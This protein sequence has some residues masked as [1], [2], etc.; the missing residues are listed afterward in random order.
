MH[1]VITKSCWKRWSAS[2]DKVVTVR[3]LRCAVAVTKYDK[4][5][6]HASTPSMLKISKC[7]SAGS[8]TSWGWS[9]FLSS[10]VTGFENTTIFLRLL[11]FQCMGFFIQG[12]PSH[13]QL[14]FLWPNQSETCQ[15]R[16]TQFS[17]SKRNCIPKTAATHK[18]LGE[19]EQRTSDC[20]HCLHLDEE[21]NT[22]KC[23]KSSY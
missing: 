19:N 13:D 20:L 4:V 3:V 1:Q 7:L 5:S 6:P 22:R 9:T 12:Q 10:F 16:Q 2:S 14:I 21:A 18:I 8:Y 11:K 17:L 15:T 23:S